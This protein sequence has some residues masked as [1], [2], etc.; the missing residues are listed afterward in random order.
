[1]WPP[2]ERLKELNKLLEDVAKIAISTGPRGAV[3]FAQ[4]IEAVVTVGG[5]YLLQILRVLIFFNL[6]NLTPSY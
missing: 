6:V 5:E 1:M 2:P 4:G 3:R